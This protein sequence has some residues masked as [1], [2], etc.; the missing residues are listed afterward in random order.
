MLDSGGTVS[1][2]EI[3]C[4]VNGVGL[5]PNPITFH[6]VHFQFQLP[7]SS[8]GAV[9]QSAEIFFQAV[10]Q[11]LFTVG[12]WTSVVPEP[13]SFTGWGLL[14][15]TLGG[16]ARLRPPQIDDQKRLRRLISASRVACPFGW[17]SLLDRQLRH[18]RKIPN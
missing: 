5:D 11:S 15:L 17:D 12:E 6:D 8:T 16:A 13:S 18:I 3:S 7:T 1:P 2:D 10:Q 14:G 9:V 4:D